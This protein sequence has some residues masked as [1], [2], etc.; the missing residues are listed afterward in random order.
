MSG[1]VLNVIL[2]DGWAEFAGRGS[3]GL[4]LELRG[5]VPAYNTRSRRWVAQ[6]HT[7]R[8]MVALAESRGWHVIITGAQ[9]VDVAAAAG[10]VPD[11]APSPPEQEGLW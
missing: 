10:D 11:P 3:R 2:G 7:A 5:R 1:R 6:L 9:A 8:D 4:Y